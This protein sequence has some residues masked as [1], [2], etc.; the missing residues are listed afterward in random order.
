[1]THDTSSL[2]TLDEWMDGV[3]DVRMTDCRPTTLTIG[4]LEWT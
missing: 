3:R 1:M 2:R 4:D